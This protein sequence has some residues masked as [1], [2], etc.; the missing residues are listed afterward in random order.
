MGE[1]K[2]NG[3]YVDKKGNRIEVVDATARERMDN[4]EDGAVV[5]YYAGVLP[6]NARYLFHDRNETRKVTREELLAV[7]FNRQIIISV[8]DANC[9]YPTH[10]SVYDGEGSVVWGRVDVLN[11][12]SLKS[13]YT[14]EYT[15]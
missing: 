10:I 5:K 3:Y 8:T 4:R 2:P 7:A 13:Y 9:Y 12:T 1:I 11:G 15:P 14:A 6:G